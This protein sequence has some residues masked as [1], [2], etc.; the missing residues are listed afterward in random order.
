MFVG[1]RARLDVAQSVMGRI[2]STTQKGAQADVRTLVWM[3]RRNMQRHINCGM[4]ESK[5]IYAIYGHPDDKS[6]RYWY[7]KCGKYIQR[8]EGSFRP[9]EEGI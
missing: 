1:R 4:P 5:I 2:S 7:A 8:S 6:C 9:E 3:G